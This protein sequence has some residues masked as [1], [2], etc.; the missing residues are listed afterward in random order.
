MNPEIGGYSGW[1]L[2]LILAVL[3]FNLACIP[4]WFLVQ[5]LLRSHDLKLKRV[6]TFLNLLDEELASQQLETPIKESIDLIRQQLQQATARGPLWGR[7][8]AA[9]AELGIYQLE[10]QDAELCGAIMKRMT[11]KRTAE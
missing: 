4:L 10:H 7:R 5:H 3:A 2:W 11:P 1:G 8:A 6:S 9:L